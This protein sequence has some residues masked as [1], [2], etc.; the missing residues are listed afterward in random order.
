MSLWFVRKV[1][2][3]MNSFFYF[4]TDSRNIASNFYNF[5]QKLSKLQIA[6]R[7]YSTSEQLFDQQYHFL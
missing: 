7:K 2:K 1:F 3:N 4:C 5:A 6:R